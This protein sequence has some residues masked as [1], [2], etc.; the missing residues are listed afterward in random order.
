MSLSPLAFISHHDSDSIVLSPAAPVNQAAIAPS[1]PSTTP[2]SNTTQNAAALPV[3]DGS[4]SGGEASRPKLQI[5]IIM[6]SLC[7]CVFVAGIDITIITTALP[8]I[9]HEFKSATGYQWIGSAYVLGSTAST[10][11][12]GKVS[13]IWGRKLMLLL[14]IL[15]FADGSL[16]CAIGTNFTVFLAGRSVQGIGAA[17]LLTL[18]NIAISDLF[19]MRDRS[20]YFGLTSIVWALA[21]GVGPVLGGV[22]SQQLS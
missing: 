20:L 5:A 18:V 15:I 21:S 13:D 9:S 22:F 16:M 14:A 10:P 12:W 11:S 4:E 19:S 7:A 8:V 3:G 1:T 2:Q 6:S 17:G